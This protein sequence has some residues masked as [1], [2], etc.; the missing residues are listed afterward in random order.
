VLLGRVHLYGVDGSLLVRE[1]GDRV[2]R[3]GVRRGIQLDVLEWGRSGDVGSS[4]EASRKVVVISAREQH[5]LRKGG[6]L[7]AA[8]AS[9]RDTRA[10]SREMCKVLIR[11]RLDGARCDAMCP[12]SGR[13]FKEGR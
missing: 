6:Q 10:P 12:R 8:R 5:E 1:S 3:R 13:S 2:V 7:E 9:V 4:S 11:R